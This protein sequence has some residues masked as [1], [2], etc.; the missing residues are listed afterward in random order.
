[1]NKKISVTVVVPA[2]NEEK[3][4]RSV[5]ESILFQS[6]KNYELDNV[7]VISDGST[8]DTVGEV[9]KVWHIKVR[10]IDDA[11]RMGKVKRLN[12]AFACNTS[13]VLIQFDADIILKDSHTI[14]KLV[15]PFIKNKKV[16]VV[17]GNQI[18]EEP[19][20]YIGK[21]AY[22][23]FYLWEEAKK[24]V[25]ADRY[26]CFGCITAFS[27]RFLDVYKLPE[28][29]FYT[30][31][32]YSFYYAKKS[33]YITYFQQSA[34]VYFKLPATFLDYVKQM[35]RYLTTANGLKTIFGEEIIHRYETITYAIKLKAFI[36]SSF[37]NSVFIVFGYFLL[38]LTTNIYTIF[39]TQNSLWGMSSSSK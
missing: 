3:N 21:L 28:D 39:H 18:P 13:D 24:M 22:F 26:N 6:Q 32:T 34:C 27:K 29:R 33:G 15:E 25:Y 8:D 35:N 31:D 9:N 10:L 5:I 38:Q 23:G 20:T 7:L 11:T 16:A 12:Y 36:K 4:I 30:E 19:K 37:K 1:M 17:Y 14:E 2:Y